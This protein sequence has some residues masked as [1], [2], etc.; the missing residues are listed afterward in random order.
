N[1]DVSGRSLMFNFIFPVI[2]VSFFFSGI[3][4]EAKDGQCFKQVSE[5]VKELSSYGTPIYN[6][7]GKKISYYMLKGKTPKNQDCSVRLDNSH[8]IY[9]KYSEIQLDSETKKT[10]VEGLTVS[11]LI[12]HRNTVESVGFEMADNSEKLAFPFTKTAVKYK[13]YRYKLASEYSDLT[14]ID[15]NCSSVSG[16]EIKD[17]GTD[18]IRFKTKT[19]STNPITSVFNSGRSATCTVNLANQKQ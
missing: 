16:L 10:P 5:I 17:L 2:V 1:F 12:P 8:S 4:S 6:I 11:L 15:S 14:N 19:D 3:S 7:S 9:W 18:N 13:I